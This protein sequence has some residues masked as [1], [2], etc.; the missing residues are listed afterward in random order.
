MD[1][2]RLYLSCALIMASAVTLLNQS[3]VI[4][5]TVSP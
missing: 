3:P 4:A 2:Q 5:A 1:R